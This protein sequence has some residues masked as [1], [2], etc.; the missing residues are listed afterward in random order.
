MAD[1]WMIRG[2]RWPD[3]GIYMDTISVPLVYKQPGEVR[4]AVFDFVDKLATDDTLTGSPTM[5]YPSGITESAS[6]RSGNRVT[7]RMSGGTAETIY[8]IACQCATTNGDT[9]ELDLDVY[10][11][12]DVN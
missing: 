1:S 12:T 4:T 9:L 5:V 10:V 7:S 8:R 11:K 6:A 3:V 2:S